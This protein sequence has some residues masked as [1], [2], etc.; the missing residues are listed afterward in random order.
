MEILSIVT[1][2]LGPAYERLGPPAAKPQHQAE[3][4]S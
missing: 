3:A 1:Q 4:A 2:E